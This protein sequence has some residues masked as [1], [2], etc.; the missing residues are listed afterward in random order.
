MTPMMVNLVLEQ[1]AR[2]NVKARRIAPGLAWVL[3]V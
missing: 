2:L 3:L 1:D